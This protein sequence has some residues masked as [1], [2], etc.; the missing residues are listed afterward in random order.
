MRKPPLIILALVAALLAF[1]W[2]RGWLE[3]L[4]APGAIPALVARAGMW[5]PLV[6]VGVSL[7][8]FALFFMS[9]PVWASTAMWPLPLAYAYSFAAGL[10]ASVLT[11]A[12]A[13]RLGQDWAQDRV[14]ASIQRWE[15][16][17]RARPFAAIFALRILLW[18][19]PLVDI[20]AAVARVPARTY[21]LATVVGL[22]P[23]TA[24][25]IFL[26]VGGSVLV[27]YLPWWGWGLI[28]AGALLGVLAARRWRTRDPALMVESARTEERTRASRAH[29][30]ARSD[31][32]GSGP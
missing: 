23:T 20:F 28:A 19:N 29:S 7:A 4:T 5:G 9:G 14:P 15:E 30:E 6:F 21:L 1:A 22:V 11:Y 2:G 27:G 18:V 3:A 17:V 10:L 25:Q 8:C 13:R 24:V 32:S 31:P 12:A 26:G 16:R